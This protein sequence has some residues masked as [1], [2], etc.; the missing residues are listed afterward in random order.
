[1]SND[2]AE[3]E[4]LRAVI[5]R[6]H[7][8]VGFVALWT[9]RDRITDAERVDAIKHHPIIRAF[10]GADAAQSRRQAL[11]GLTAET[12]RLGLYDNGEHGAAVPEAE[13]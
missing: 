11:D 12:E 9:N 5:K 7:N 10:D 3:M 4:R 1:M 8:F 13:K 2:L 6:Y